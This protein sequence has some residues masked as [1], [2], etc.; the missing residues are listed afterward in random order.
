MLLPS[1]V[2]VCS[3]CNLFTWHLSYMIV[4]TRTQFRC[5]VCSSIVPELCSGAGYVLN[6]HNYRMAQ[7]TQWVPAILDYMKKA[8][9]SISTCYVFS[10]QWANAIDLH[11]H[12]SCMHVA[13]RVLHSCAFITTCRSSVWDPVVAIVSLE[14]KPLTTL[15]ICSILS[16]V[17]LTDSLDYYLPL[18]QSQDYTHIR[19]W[20]GISNQLDLRWPHRSLQR[21]RTACAH[22]MIHELKRSVLE[23]ELSKAFCGFSGIEPHVQQRDDGSMGGVLSLAT[24][25]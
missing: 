24:R 23:Q 18:E 10:T 21:V 25:H 20:T 4:A 16:A 17:H 8:R 19:P 15:W 11:A 7:P 12:E 13:V 9:L 14:D 6:R 2:V 5:R 1:G 3:C 22:T